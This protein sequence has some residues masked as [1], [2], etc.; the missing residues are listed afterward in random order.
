MITEALNNEI[1]T[2]FS[3]LKIKYSK[4]CMIIY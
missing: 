4:N 3:V 1:Q 2:Q